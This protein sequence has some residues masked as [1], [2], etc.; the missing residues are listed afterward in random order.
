MTVAVPALL[1]DALGALAANPEAQVL[2]GGTDFMVE[3]NF[4]KRRPDAVVAV[5]H[6]PELRGWSRTNGH[7]TLGAGLTY[8]EMLEPPL[9]QFLP[10][11][12]MAARTVGSPQ[13]RNAGT[14]GGNL[15]TASPAGDTLPV[16]AALDA[17]VVPQNQN[18]ERT[19]PLDEMIIGPK[20][21][22]LRQD[23]LIREVQVPVLR[24]PQQFLK[25]GARNA[26]VIAVSSLALVVDLDGRNVRCALGSAGPRPLRTPNAEHWVADRID[27]AQDAA[28]IDDPD[29]FATFG[30]LVASEAQSID[31][32]RG[33]AVYRNRSIAVMARRALERVTGARP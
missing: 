7:L 29:T 4:G 22:A 18:T 15:A 11:L 31:D 17:K 8:T 23:E 28:T 21:N 27:W 32:H 24:G 14:V 12:A 33:T 5:G 6:L 2:A 1:D 19:V 13:I 26:M 16:L 30:D 3:V 10:A 9:A 20:Q 25:V